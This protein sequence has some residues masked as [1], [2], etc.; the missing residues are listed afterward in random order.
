[1]KDWPAFEDA[2][3][4]LEYLRQHFKLITLTNCD[5]ISYAGSNARLGEPWDA[6]YTAQDVGSY[7]P[8]HRNFDYLLEHVDAEFGLNSDD[9]LHVA[10]SLFHDHVPA[11]A[12]GISGAWIDRRKN[13]E[14]YGATLPPSGGYELAYHF[15][16]MADLVDAHKREVAAG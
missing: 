14:G 13:V 12:Y 7:K 11:T 15:A 5:R 3:A 9:I 16:S 8:D 4:S 1:M 2:K 6:I 10:Q